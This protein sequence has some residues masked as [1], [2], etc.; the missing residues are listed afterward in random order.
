[1]RTVKKNCPQKVEKTTLKSWSEKLNSRATQSAGKEEFT[2][3]IVAFR[4]TVYRTWAW[5]TKLENV[6]CT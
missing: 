3:Q 5:D 6:R 1:M 2:F 4:P